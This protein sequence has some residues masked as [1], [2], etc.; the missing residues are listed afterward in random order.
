[1]SEIITLKGKMIN[2][3]TYGELSSIC[4]KI[5]KEIKDKVI[6]SNVKTNTI[7]NPKSALNMLNLSLV[8]GDEIEIIIISD[9]NIN[10]NKSKNSILDIFKNNISFYKE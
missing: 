4:E 1:M 5:N 10:L 8:N 2:C 3:F 7:A 6:L 9:N